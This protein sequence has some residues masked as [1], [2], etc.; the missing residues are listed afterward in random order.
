MDNNSGYNDHNPDIPNFGT[1]QE[2]DII[3]QNEQFERQERLKRAALLQR[4]ERIRRRK[5]QQLKQTITAWSILIFV[6]ICVVSII[7]GIV[8]SVNNKND[9]KKSGENK[10]SEKILSAYSDFADDTYNFTGENGASSFD[11]YTRENNSF[12]EYL[13]Y[14]SYYSIISESSSYIKHNYTDAF[15]DAVRDC[16]IFSNGYIWSSDT[17]MK[18]PLTDGYLYD[19]NASFICAAGDI[20]NWDKGTDFLYYRDETSA[21][22]KDVSSGM[23]VLE[24]V[25]LAADYFFDKNDLNGGGIRYNETDGLVYILTQAN[26]GLSSGKPSNIF[27]NHLFGYLDLYNNILFN[28]AMVSLDSIYTKLGDTAKA[29]HYKAIAAKNKAAI[30]DKFYNNSL[31]RYVG[32]IDKDGNV[33]DLGYTAVNLMAISSSITQKEQSDKIFSWING[34]NKI[35]SDTVSGEKIYKGKKLPIFNT[36]CALDESWFDKDG[37]SAY[38]GSENYGKCSFNG[39]ESFAGAY[40]N[41]AASG[42]AQSKKKL[43]TNIEKLSKSI[44]LNTVGTGEDLFA[45]S[46]AYLGAKNLFGIDTDG[47][48]L[49]VSPA[50]S[51]GSSFAIRNIA[52][53]GNTYSFKFSESQILITA[54][55]NT[56]VK[57]KL[58]SYEE[59]D[60]FKLSVIENENIISEETVKADKD[61][62]VSVYKRFGSTSFI[63]LE[64]QEQNKK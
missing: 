19:T 26:N 30:N 59:G 62:L 24:K 43:G 49:F 63:V 47:E 20:C 48:I 35:N 22:S 7:V 25:N 54:Y 57:I 58:G 53:G 21:G 50:F 8:S 61:G 38:S 56:A 45:L 29:S 18:Y 14:P 34:E 16:P 12:E 11:G 1:R 60:A 32:Y 41:I 33:H 5:L 4:Q 51:A 42:K 37:T 17:S 3:R 15:R 28:K 27:H 13:K 36:I 10:A 46:S 31:G 55:L 2:M 9:G 44:S 64:K 40:Y 39:G 6:V 23:S 52:F